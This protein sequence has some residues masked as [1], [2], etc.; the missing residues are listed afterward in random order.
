MAEEFGQGNFGTGMEETG[1]AFLCPNSFAYALQ[2]GKTNGRGIG[3][4]EFTNRNARNWRG[5]P[6]P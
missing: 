3:A 5:I 6:M 1:A 2:K 4:R